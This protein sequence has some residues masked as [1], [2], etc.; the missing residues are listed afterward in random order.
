MSGKT[1][2]TCLHGRRHFQ[3]P[4][5]ARNLGVT[6]AGGRVLRCHA[7]PRGSPAPGAERMAW[8]PHPAFVCLC[9]QLRKR[10]HREV[11]ALPGITQCPA[12]TLV[13]PLWRPVPDVGLAGWG[14]P[15]GGTAVLSRHC[16]AP[17][18]SAHRRVPQQPAGPLPALRVQSGCPQMV[19]PQPPDPLPTLALR[20]SGSSEWPR[21]ER[22]KQPA[23]R[24]P[25][26]SDL[27]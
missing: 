26:T 23:H 3:R 13:R 2:H 7:R 10:R 16:W 15:L 8:W 11:K 25:S 6:W 17:Q 27:L 18:V 12:P 14:L 21:R 24:V 9:W 4:Q 20:A 22:M 1:S 5:A 19:R